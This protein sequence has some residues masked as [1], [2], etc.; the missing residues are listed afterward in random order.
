MVVH[1]VE[2]AALDVGE[3]VRDVTGVVARLAHDLGH[4]HGEEGAQLSGGV[5][6]AG[7][8]QNDLVATRHQPVAELLDDPLRASVA[9]GRHGDPRRG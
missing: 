6:V 2:A 3:G 4:L 1:E 8:V 7:G 9:G 5:R